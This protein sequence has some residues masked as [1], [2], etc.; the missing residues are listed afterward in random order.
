MINS[1]PFSILLTIILA[2]IGVLGDYFI[3]LSGSGSKYIMLWP[4]FTGMVIYALTA[5]GWFFVMKHI[6]LG[7]LAIFYTVTTVILLAIVGFVFF[8]EQLS[9][10]DI[11]G[12]VLGVASLV[13]LA[14][15]G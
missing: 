11:L 8:K 13:I 4:F 15:F 9:I 5:F 1:V 2:A 7:Q 10:Y 6:K 12:L 3:K 14:R